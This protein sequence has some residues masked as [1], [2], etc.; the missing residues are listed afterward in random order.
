[1]ELLD[2]GGNALQIVFRDNFNQNCTSQKLPLVH[3]VPC[4][5]MTALAAAASAAKRRHGMAATSI[6]AHVELRTDFVL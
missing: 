5:Q 6:R 3:N 2:G 1:M 4:V